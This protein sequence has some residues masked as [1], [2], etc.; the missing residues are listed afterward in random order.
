M[1]GC[2]TRLR[3]LVVPTRLLLAA[4]AVL[5]LAACGSGTKKPAATGASAPPPAPST[6]DPR[7]AELQATIAALQQQLAAAQ[8]TPSVAPTVVDVTPPTPSASAGPSR[9]ASAPAA[10]RVP[11]SRTPTRATGQGQPLALAQTGFAQ[12][13][14]EIAYAFVV[15]N[16]NGDAAIM[17]SEYQVAAYDAGGAVID[18]DSG[19]IDIIFPGEKLGIAGEIFANDAAQK[20]AKIQVQIKSGTVRAGTDKDPLSVANVTLQTSTFSQS[21]TGVVSN[22]GTSDLKDVQVYSIA[23][24]A[25]G[26]IIGGGLTFLDFVPAGGSSA[27]KVSLTTSARPA[28]V[29]MYATYSPL[30][31]SF[32]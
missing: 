20:A 24:D 19:S 29:E 26:A 6:P 8:K 27:A 10:T 1:P 3:T 12:Q 25:G 22:A 17:D 2:G 14:T 7:I 21:A 23:Y 9:T 28:K 16:P 30:L 4:C 13:D 18:T 5:C 11:A 32:D 31:N 15:S